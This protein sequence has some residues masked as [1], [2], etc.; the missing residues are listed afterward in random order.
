MEP[1]KACNVRIREQRPRRLTTI[2]A[3]Q[4]VDPFKGGFIQSTHEGVQIL[5]RAP[6]Q[7]FEKSFIFLSLSGRQGR[8]LIKMVSCQNSVY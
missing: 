8:K 3:I 2:G 7:L 1:G 5:G 4:A 6:F